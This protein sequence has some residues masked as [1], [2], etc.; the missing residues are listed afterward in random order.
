MKRHRGGDLEGELRGVHLVIRS[1]KKSHLQ[2]NKR[3]AGKHAFPHCL[4]R[5]L[6]NRRDI[7]M[8]DDAAL[9][10][11]NKLKTLAA[12]KR[13][14]FDLHM[15]ILATAAG[16][17]DILALGLGFFFNRLLVGDLR[18]ADIRFDRELA[19]HPVYDNFKMQL[20]HAGYDRLAGF[21]I[22][23]DAEGWVLFAKP[24]KRYTHLLLI[25]LRLRLDTHRYDR[26]GECYALQDYW[27]FRINQTIAGCRILE[28]HNRAQIPGINLIHL[29]SVI[30]V[31][32]DN[33]SHAF[34]L[35]LCRIQNITSLFHHAGINP[36]E[37]ERS[38]KWIRRD[39][40][41]QRR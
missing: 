14:D 8:R 28:T 18:P 31:H 22:A 35:S 7:L 16:L 26:L 24:P 27:V 23:S 30:G 1:V 25:N 3:I 9:D 11:V 4:Y 13:L 29:L 37:C 12:F 39:L 19:F 40:K 21:G 20:A 32:A 2:I 33:P 15:S 34:L 36:E 17:T 10:R 38:H 6:F 41:S 5:A